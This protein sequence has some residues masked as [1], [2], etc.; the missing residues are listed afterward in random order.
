MCW[1]G[2]GWVDCWRGGGGGGGVGKRGKG[3]GGVGWSGAGIKGLRRSIF[4]DRGFRRDGLEG[5][6]I[7]EL[8]EVRAGWSWRDL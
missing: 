5:V 6:G 1:V 4:G 8:E 7:E 2:L 3:W